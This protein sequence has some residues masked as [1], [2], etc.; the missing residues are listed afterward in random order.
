[1]HGITE[2]ARDLR[3]ARRRKPIIAVADP[4]AAS[5]AYWLAAQATDVVATPSGY[6]GSIGIIC[7]HEDVSEQQRQ[8]GVTTTVISSGK[9]KAEAHPFA[10]LTVEARAELQRKCDEQHQRF[11]AD[12]AEGRGLSVATVEGTYGQGRI[13]SA[14]Q[15][16]AA[17]MIDAVLS[18]DGVLQRVHDGRVTSVRTGRTSAAVAAGPVPRPRT[19]LDLAAKRLALA[20]ARNR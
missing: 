11:V 16:L 12:V 9:Y 4:L 3:E 18:L 14:S 5:A 19:P 20:I 15:A 7:A 8:D 2:L 1:V 17:G 13:V 10:P 6:V